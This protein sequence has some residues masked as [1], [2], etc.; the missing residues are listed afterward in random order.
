MAIRFNCWALL[1]LVGHMAGVHT[2]TTV[3]HEKGFEP[4]VAMYCGDTQ[5]SWDLF[6]ATKDDENFLFIEEINDY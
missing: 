3:K 6:F 5:G 1:L 4:M 2:A